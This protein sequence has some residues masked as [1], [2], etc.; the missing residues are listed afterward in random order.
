MLEQDEFKFQVKNLIKSSSK[1]FLSVVVFGKE[2]LGMNMVEA[3]VAIVTVEHMKSVR[4][5]TQLC[6]NRWKVL[7]YNKECKRVMEYEQEY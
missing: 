7:K 6:D 3:H 4:I 5:Q 1:T 2:L